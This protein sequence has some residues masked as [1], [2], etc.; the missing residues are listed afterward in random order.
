LAAI[1]LWERCEA[2]ARYIF[3]S[4]VGDPVADEILRALKVRGGDGMTR[5]EIRDLFKRHEKGERIG[6]ALDLLAN[7]GLAK[8]EKRSTGGAPAEIWRAA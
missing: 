4:A 6:L 2:S 5:T 3:G 8:S 7:K 1:A